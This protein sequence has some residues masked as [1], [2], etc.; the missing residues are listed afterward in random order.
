VEGDIFEFPAFCLP[1]G[2][3]SRADRS[4]ERVGFRASR[5]DAGTLPKVGKI[6][7]RPD[8]HIA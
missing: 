5:H 4:G 7:V 2:P 6:D 3:K 8:E 1:K